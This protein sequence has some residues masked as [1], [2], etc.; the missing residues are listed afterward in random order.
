M[1]QYKD[2]G[3]YLRQR[4]NAHHLSL[5]ET[6]KRMGF[7]RGYLPSIASGAFTPSREKCLKIAEFFNDPPNLVLEL[8]GYFFPEEDVRQHEEIARIA[9]ALSPADQQLL[10]EIAHILKE[11][12][13]R[14]V[15]QRQAGPGKGTSAQPKT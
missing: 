10:L 13:D 6:S 3:D 2:L 9:T 8:A 12:A 1:S 11:R 15:S 7:S 4:C 14:R 5:V